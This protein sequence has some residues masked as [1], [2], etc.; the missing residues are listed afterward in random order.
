MLHMRTGA[1]VTSL[2]DGRILVAGGYN[3]Y[4][5]LA[6]WADYTQAEVFDP[7]TLSWSDGGE[8]KQPRDYPAAAALSGGR[9]LLMGGARSDTISTTATE[10]FSP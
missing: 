7:A 8:M 3:P 1:S 5:P 6:S 2:D 10:I 4:D 9:I